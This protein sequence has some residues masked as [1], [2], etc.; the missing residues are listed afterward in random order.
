MRRIT[1]HGFS[2]RLTPPNAMVRMLE[3]PFTTDP[4]HGTM[5]PVCGPGMARRQHCALQVR[6]LPGEYVHSWRGAASPDVQRPATRIRRT[7][8]PPGP[9]RRRALH[10]RGQT[11]PLDRTDRGHCAGFRR[12]PRRQRAGDRGEPPV[13]GDERQPG[14]V[15]SRR[16]PRRALHH[17]GLGHRIRETRGDRRVRHRGSGHS[18]RPHD[19]ALHRGRGR[20]P[21][22][23]RQAGGG[24]LAGDVADGSDAGRGRQWAAL[25]GGRADEHRELRHYRGVTLPPGGHQPALHLLDRR[26]RREL[27]QRAPLP[28]RR[29]AATAG[30][31][32]D[33]GV[34]QLLPVR[35]SRAQ[36]RG[37]VQRH[38]RP[39]GGAVGDGAPAAPQSGSRA[40]RSGPMPCPPATWSSC[41]TSPAHAAAQQAAAGEAGLPPAG[42][43]AAPAGPR[44][45]RGLR[46]RRRSGAALHARLGQGGDPRR[47]STGWRPGGSTAGGA[48]LRLAYEIAPAALRP[49][50]ATTA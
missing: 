38:H 33:R 11:A 1:N 47:R 30:R 27:H 9:A 8:V 17:P 10:R 28:D 42:A 48:G 45:D 41:W 31:R 7:H 32:A 39:R 36:G 16:H 15:P 26:R 34:P 50:G 2:P 19:E 5:S 37:P 23:S 22:R 40:G 12:R 21:D 14:K 46:R 44:G 43:G 49:R 35:L 4:S 3:V 24:R 29:A 25:P 6:L 18:A 13:D 20:R